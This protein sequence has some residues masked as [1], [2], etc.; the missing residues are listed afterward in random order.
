MTF[1]GILRWLCFLVINDHSLLFTICTFNLSLVISRSVIINN[2]WLRVF[3][4]IHLLILK[5]SIRALLLNSALA[6]Y[7]RVMLIASS[8]SIN[9]CLYIGFF[10]S[11]AT[12][13]FLMRWNLVIRRSVIPRGLFIYI[14][15][16]FHCL[17]NPFTVL[18]YH[19]II[20]LWMNGFGGKWYK[21]CLCRFNFNLVF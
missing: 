9:P 2:Y 11:V 3:G 12:I 18:I 15:T 19:F 8:M 5:V 6:S 4:P 1:Y 16:W 13:L 17:L 14:L 20:W 7:L 10:N 21:W